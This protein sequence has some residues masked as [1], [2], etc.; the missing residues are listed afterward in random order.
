MDDDIRAVGGLLGYASAGDPDAPTVV[1]LHGVGT[2]SWMWRRLIDDLAGELHVVSVDLP[3]HGR[4][5]ERNLA[6]PD[7]RRVPEYVRV[8]NGSVE[9][10]VRILLAPVE[11]RQLGLSLEDPA[12]L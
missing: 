12:C 4:A 1:L 7:I 5:R 6:T 2:P 8:R 10:E 3:G 11:P 9:V